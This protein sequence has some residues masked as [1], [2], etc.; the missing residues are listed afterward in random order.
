[1]DVNERINEE[2][3][4][5]KNEFLQAVIRYSMT[6]Q[7]YNDVREVLGIIYINTVSTASQQHEQEKL[8]FSDNS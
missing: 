5:S 3:G 1:M 6:D 4:D 7:K 8:Y 2:N